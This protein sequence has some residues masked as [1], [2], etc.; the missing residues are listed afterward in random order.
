MKI[1]SPSLAASAV[2][3]VSCLAW[4]GAITLA[5][6]S[7]MELSTETGW[8]IAAFFGCSSIA[9][10]SF[11]LYEL[12][13]AMEMPN[14]VDPVDYLDR[15]SPSGWTPPAASSQTAVNPAPAFRTHG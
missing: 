11:I 14:D 9:A 10:V 1:S 12:R 2:V 3:A 13:N 6:M 8:Q 15:P 4:T 7:L 5:L